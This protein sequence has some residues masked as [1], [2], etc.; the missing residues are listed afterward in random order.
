MAIGINTNLLETNIINLSVVVG[1]VIYLGGDVL[2]SLLTAR[3]DSILKTLNAAEEKY[4]Q[5]LIALKQA[6]DDLTTARET[7]KTI[8]SESQTTLQNRYNF[9]LERIQ[10]DLVRLENSQKVALEMEEAKIGKKLYLEC[11]SF[12]LQEAKVKVQNRLKTRSSQ[13]KLIDTNISV[14]SQF[15]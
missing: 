4:Q 15:L 8:Q 3:K 10:Q 7:V 13:Q 14:L 6:E 11:T 9:L 1:V 5:T 12:A 2:K